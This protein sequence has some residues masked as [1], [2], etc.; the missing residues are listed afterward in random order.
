M[1]EV[2]SF[3]KI[4][5]LGGVQTQMISFFRYQLIN[6]GN[7]RHHLLAIHG[8]EEHFRDLECF[9]I[10]WLKAILKGKLATT[11]VHSHNTL[12]SSRYLNFWRLVKPSNLI[13]HEHGNIWNVKQ[14]DPIVIASTN[15]AKII[16]A[17]SRATAFMLEHKFGVDS[18][19]IRIIH[20]GV[21]SQL[22]KAPQQ[23][24]EEKITIGYLGR[25]EY[26]KGVHILIEAYQLLPVKLKTNT[27]LKIIG[28]GPEFEN[29][30]NLAGNNPGIHFLGK[31]NN[32]PELLEELDIIVAPSIREPLGNSIIE[33]GL[34]RK[35]VIASNI[36]GIPEIITSENLGI[37]IRPSLPLRACTKNSPV[38]VYDPIAE[39]IVAP[40]EIDPQIL[41]LALQKLITNPD[42]RQSLGNN[43]FESIKE[44]FSI[45]QYVSQIN[46]IYKE[47]SP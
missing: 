23:K 35:P 27:I 7:I 19:K 45:Q 31:R 12:T 46:S 22:P 4:R 10:S 47:L 44:R 9:R 42:F 17:N 14:N 37:L 36:D 41:S 16:I 20:N 11:I 6:P 13:L 24:D 29:L 2:I 38:L 18:K 25:L 39:K 43:L 15:L 8:F 32:I 21:F 34:Y 1:N 33:A 40:Q 30:K 5:G 28:D 26:F 3:L